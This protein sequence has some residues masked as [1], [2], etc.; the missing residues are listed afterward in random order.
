MTCQHCLL[1]VPDDRICFQEKFEEHSYSRFC[2]LSFYL[3]VSDSG[4][5]FLLWCSCRFCLR[6]KAGK[7]HS[8]SEAK[9]LPFWRYSSPLAFQDSLV[10]MVS[11]Y[12]TRTV[13]ILSRGATTRTQMRYLRKCMDK[14][15]YTDAFLTGQYKTER[16]KMVDSLS[17]PP[18][19]LC[20]PSWC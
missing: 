13:T 7:S 10:P 2:I 3:G 1:E 17:D 20:T 5:T 9:L 18:D 4:F 6:S 11:I 15:P 12:W 19:M 16:V 8:T 14:T